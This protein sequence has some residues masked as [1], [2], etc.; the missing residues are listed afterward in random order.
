MASRISFQRKSLAEMVVESKLLTAEQLETALEIHRKTNRELGDILIEQGMLTEEDLATMMSIQ[1]NLPLIDLKRHKVQ[2]DALRLLPEEMARKY[3]IVPLDIIGDSLVVI[4]TDPQD[5]EALEEL[6]TMAKM[7]IKPA[8]GI[9]SQIRQAIDINYK[10]SVEI[11]KQISKIA[12]PTIDKRVEIALLTESIATTPVVRIVDLL[13][14]QAVKDRASDIHLEPQKDRLR[15]R[16]RIDGILHDLSSL[17]LEVHSTLISRIKVLAEMDISERRRPQDGQFPFHVDGKE[18]DIRAATFN[19]I[20]GEMAV[21]RLL[22]KSLSFLTLSELGLLP[23]AL[24]KYMRMLRSPLGMILVAGPTGSGKTTTLYASV[25]QLDRN[26]RNII[27][28]EDPAEYEFTDIN[29]SEINPKADITFASG[30][31]SILR[32]DP[33]V[34][35]IGEMRD[36][37]TAQIAVQAALTGHLMLSSI[38]ANDAIGVLF[39]LAHLDV[40]PFLLS[41]ALLG[42]VAQ[43]M[44]RCVC[45]HCRTPSQ[46]KGEEKTA[47]EE[48]MKEVPTHFYY[49]TGCNFCAETGYKGRTGVFEIL[50]VTEEIRTLLTSGASADEIRA[51]AIKEG[52]MTMRRDGMIKVKQG[53]TT[54][55]EV[56]RNVFSIS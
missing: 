35:L 49:G 22:D 41:S 23:E 2:P 17:P 14:H 43:R 27:T 21:L 26:E 5:I 37:E 39:R 19:T 15:I 10:A 20:Y 16:Y 12:P 54:P 4:M 47:Y 30:L 34:I 29:S 40:D 11:A 42:V 48:E 52:M 55:Y 50:L 13:I 6:A 7:R 9:P 46:P 32:L 24:E 44:L 28:V 3:N 36:A 53:I 38:H 51:Q 31:R 18:V 1:L 45:P 33:D 25:N 8:M 56:L